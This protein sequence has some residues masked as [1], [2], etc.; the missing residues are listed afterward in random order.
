MAFTNWFGK[1]EI[2]LTPERYGF[3]KKPACGIE[4]FIEDF[5]KAAAANELEV[6]KSGDGGIWLADNLA[7]Q[8]M[9]INPDGTVEI[10]EPAA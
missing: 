4:K 10:G 3:W 7:G 1:L 5:A 8:W 9:V 6:A 2:D